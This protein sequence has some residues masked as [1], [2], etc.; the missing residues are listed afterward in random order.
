MF[1]LSLAYE[2]LTSYVDSFM[3]SVT[4]FCLSLLGKVPTVLTCL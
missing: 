3:Y 4:S 1:P 2:G